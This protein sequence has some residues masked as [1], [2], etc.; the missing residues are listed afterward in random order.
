MFMKKSALR[1]SIIGAGITGL[2]AAWELQRYG[3]QSEV[4]E[5]TSLVGGRATSVH[6]DGFIFDVGAIT[7]LP[8][9]V[10]TSALIDELG[11]GD[12]LHRCS[13]II[14]IPRGGEIHDIDFNVLLRSLVG[15]ELVSLK[16]KLKI[17]KLMPS[18][19][20]AWNSI[21]YSSLAPLSRW[22][23]ESIAQWAEKEL[24]TE[25]HNYVVGPIIRG[26]TL[27]STKDAPFG[28]LLWMLKA[29]CSP[30][31]QNF[32]L[33]IGFFAES[34]AKNAKIHFDTKID[35]IELSGEHVTLRGEGLSEYFD[36]CIVALPPN[37]LSEIDVDIPA[38]QKQFLVNFKPL[39][40][41]NFHFG[42]KKRPYLHQAFILPPES[43]S[44]I[45]TTIVLDHNKAPGRAPAGKGV[46]SLFCRDTWCADN[47]YRPESDLILE[48]LEMAKPFIGDISGDIESHVVQRWPYATIKSEVGLYNHIAEFEAATDVQSR[49][50]V[51]GDFYSMGIEA[52]VCSGITSAERLQAI[53]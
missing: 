50:Q 43:E 36:A 44:E 20:R 39:R 14:G 29:Y 8:T 45:L 21:Q 49:I 18:L 32:D 11:I 33:G 42:L 3:I 28:E 10:R 40:S 41:V 7:L 19:W 24:G 5:K 27:N 9:Y 1:V 38:A 30:F 53:L 12:H 37:A 31:I 46:I 2:T 23:G 47:F 15:T 17:L 22:D 6:Q 16:S 13:P 34:L 26:N 25:L 52:A 35:T 48:A 51:A 4:F